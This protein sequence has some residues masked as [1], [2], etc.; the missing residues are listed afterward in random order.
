MLVSLLLG[1]RVSTV[2]ARTV[3]VRVPLGAQD[4]FVQLYADGA[5]VAVIHLSRVEARALTRAV[6]AALRKK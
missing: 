1:E 5:I 6:T 2:V 4:I 3:D